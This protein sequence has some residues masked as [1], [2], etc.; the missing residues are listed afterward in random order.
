[1]VN[2]ENIR[3][4]VKQIS[5]VE[6]HISD[7]E[8]KIDEIQRQHNMP[9]EWFTEDFNADNQHFKSDVE[10]SAYEEISRYHSEIGV[11][12]KKIG[13]TREALKSISN[14]INTDEADDVVEAKIKMAILEE[15]LRLVV[16]I[17][18]KYRHQAPEMEFLDLVVAGNSGL[19][20]AI[21]NYDYQ[22]GFQ[23]KTYAQWWIR[24]NVSRAIAGQGANSEC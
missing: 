11:Y 15:N 12:L 4:I 1:M 14:Q 19:L 18:K 21:D 16:N 9:A 20:S 2:S 23:F 7:C 13:L 17:A 22:R 8:Q 24:Q 6:R 5:E 3:P 10:K